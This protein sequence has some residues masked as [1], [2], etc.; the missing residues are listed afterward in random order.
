MIHFHEEAVVSNR[1]ALR[2]RTVQVIATLCM[3]PQQSPDV[4]AKDASS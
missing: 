2:H 4:F 3:L 1:N